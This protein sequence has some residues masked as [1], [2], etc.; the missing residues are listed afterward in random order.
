MI[1]V[2]SLHKCSHLYNNLESS[3]F[4]I[5]K[6]FTLFLLCSPHSRTDK[7]ESSSHSKKKNKHT[8]KKPR[9]SGPFVVSTRAWIRPGLLYPK[10]IK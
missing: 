4:F 10:V 8:Q 1:P 5:S 9:S 3:H 2:S 6:L 7:R